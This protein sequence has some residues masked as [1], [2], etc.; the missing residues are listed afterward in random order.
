MSWLEVTTSV[1]IN[2]SDRTNKYEVGFS[3]S[4]GP[5]EF[6]WGRDYPIYFMMKIGKT[7]KAS[8]KKIVMDVNDAKPITGVVETTHPSDNIIYFGLY[9]AWSGKWKGGLRI[10]YAFARPLA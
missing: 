5:D 3:I 6:G 4:F 10:H 9:E 2:K 7:G 8:W 1:N